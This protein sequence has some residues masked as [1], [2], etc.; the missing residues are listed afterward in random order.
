MFLVTGAAMYS[1]DAVPMGTSPDI[2]GV[3]IAVVSLAG[4][5]SF[6]MAV[7]TS[8]IVQYRNDGF[9]CANRL[10]I[11]HGG[12]CFSLAMITA[13]GDCLNREMKY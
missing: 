3:P 4:K 10:T 7:H 13:C 6:G 9:K 2:H 5:I 8:R 1:G 11:V 12:L